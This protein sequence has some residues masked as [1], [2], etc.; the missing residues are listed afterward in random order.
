V[1]QVPGVENYCEMTKTRQLG[2]TLDA[3]ANT[4]SFKMN[5]PELGVGM[6]FFNNIRT[7]RKA[8]AFA[9]SWPQGETN[10][11]QTD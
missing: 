6:L 1:L 7:W 5:A 11:A 8:E 10:C 9:Y 2:W 4:K 3:T